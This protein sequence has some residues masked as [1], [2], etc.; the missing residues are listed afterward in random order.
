M[1]WTRG[2][3]VGDSPARCREPLIAIVLRQVRRGSAVG[4]RLAFYANIA[5]D[6]R[7]R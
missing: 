1:Q 7:R 3:V 4:P 5:V 2:V 6:L